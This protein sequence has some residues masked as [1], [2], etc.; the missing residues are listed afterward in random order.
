MYGLHAK[1][2]GRESI[3]MSIKY[4]K[5]MKGKA[6][7]KHS[8]HGKTAASVLLKLFISGNER[9]HTIEDIQSQVGSGKCLY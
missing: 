4:I 3:S 5:H 6:L 7:G 2:V 1:H 9:C 8:L